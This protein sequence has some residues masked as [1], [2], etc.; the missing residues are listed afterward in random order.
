MKKR[1]AGYC[2]RRRYTPICWISTAVILAVGIAPTT[3]PA[4]NSPIN[5]PN[6]FKGMK[7]PFK[8]VGSKLSKALGGDADVPEASLS[9]SEKD[10]RTSSKEYLESLVLQAAFQEFVTK[11]VVTGVA[12]YFLTQKEKECAIAGG[13]TGALGGINYYR[14]KIDVVAREDDI[15]AAEEMTKDARQEVE[16]LKKVTNNARQVE[17]ENTQQIARLRRE[18]EQEQLAADK[19]VQERRRL[20]RNVEIVQESLDAGNKELKRWQDTLDVQKKAGQP[21]AELEE[22]VVTKRKELKKLEDTHARMNERL[23]SLPIHDDPI[24]TQPTQGVA[25]SGDDDR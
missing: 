22:Q 5:I 15:R 23:A 6:P 17:N 9:K 14:Q 2:A 7:N 1:R 25:S 10:L 16:H 20:E 11:G 4:Q 3:A 18:I 13:V 24:R 21:S 19:A 12:C 8:D